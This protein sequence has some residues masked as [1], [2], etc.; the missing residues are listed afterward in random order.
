MPRPSSRMRRSKRPA[1]LK[2]L[3]AASVRIA[4]ATSTAATLKQI[5]DEARQ[6]VGAHLAATHRVSN[7]NWK[8]ASIVVSLSEKYERF[9]SFSIPPNGSGIYRRAIEAGQPLR[10]TASEL[11]AHPDWRGL[12]G[13]KADHPPLRGLVAIPISGRGGES[14]GV[15]MPSDKEDGD[16]TPEDEAILVQAEYGVR[17]Y[18]YTV[19]NDRTVLVD[20]RTHRVI[21]IVE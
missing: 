1:L 2:A 15:I 7:A 8:A 3:A 5:T 18:R 16:F 13:C 10:L 19:V 12:S 21:Q 11:A 4:S 9:A 6:I 17:D 20:P 14:I